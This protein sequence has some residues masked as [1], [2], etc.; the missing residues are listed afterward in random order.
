MVN[1]VEKRLNLTQALGYSEIS[2]KYKHMFVNLRDV[3]K[4]YTNE[5]LN[6]PNLFNGPEH[7]AARQESYERARALYEASKQAKQKPKIVRR[8]SK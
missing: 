2:P 7:D 8:K 3:N 6:D 1:V 4:M 5:Q